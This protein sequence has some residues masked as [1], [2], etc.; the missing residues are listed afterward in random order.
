MCISAGSHS[1]PSCCWI[2][3]LMSYV[4]TPSYSLHVASQGCTLFWLFHIPCERNC[5]LA[6]PLAFSRL[7]LAGE[8]IH[9]YVWKG[10][11]SSLIPPLVSQKHVSASGTDSSEPSTRTQQEY[12]CARDPYRSD[13]WHWFPLRSSRSVLVS[14]LGN[15]AD[16]VQAWRGPSPVMQAV[17]KCSAS[18]QSLCLQEYSNIKVPLRGM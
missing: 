14:A 17:F 12:I 3:T 6:R 8:I 4:Y 11:C 1:L 13:H 16:V 18:A 9:G 10:S 2:Q 15:Q 7:H 5:F